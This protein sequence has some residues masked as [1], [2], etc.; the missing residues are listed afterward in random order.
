MVEFFGAAVGGTVG[1]ILGMSLLVCFRHLACKRERGIE[2]R[3][4]EIIKVLKESP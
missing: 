2:G 4:D 1:A 3:L